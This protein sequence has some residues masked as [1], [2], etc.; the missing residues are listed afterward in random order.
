MDR[1]YIETFLAKNRNL[2]KGTVLEIAESSYS[3]RFGTGITKYEVLHVTEDNPNATI[4]GDL[5]D[6]ETLPKDQIDCFICT[7]TFNFIYDFQDA[8]KGAY[9]LLKP[10]GYLLATVSGISQISAYDMERWGDFWRFTTLS[11]Q[12]AFGQ[13]FTPEQIEVDFFGNCLAATSFLRGVTA[14]EVSKEKLEVKDKDYQIV[15]TVV[16][17]K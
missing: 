7:Q 11:T 3:K 13:V 14:E 15:I 6:F 10:G 17:R 8:I 12:K 2:I 4:I 9:H 1:Y 5:T 16:A